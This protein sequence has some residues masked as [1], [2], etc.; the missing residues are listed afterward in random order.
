MFA[1][2]L[3]GLLVF[4]FGVSVGAGM[5]QKEKPA[6]SELQQKVQQHM[7]VIADESAA[8]VDDVM[9]ELRENENVKEA[10]QFVEDVREIMGNTA[11]DIH[12]HFGNDE[13]EEAASEAA[14]D[15][16]EAA[17]EVSEAAEEI[18]E[19]VEAVIEDSTEGAA[20]GN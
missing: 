12:A 20:E 5:P 10:E 9:D 3:K 1:S 19:A 13:A 14:E 15:I 8:I 4:L 11:D 2:L 7:D 16:E 17:E 6:D 18:G